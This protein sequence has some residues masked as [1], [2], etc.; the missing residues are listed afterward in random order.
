MR[1]AI[2]MT[3]KCQVWNQM[4]LRNEARKTASISSQ[5]A[6]IGVGM[7][8]LAV[9]AGEWVLRTRSRLEARA[10]KDGR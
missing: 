6:F 5:I 10:K 7:E 4:N 8:L 1:E 2:A 3:V 9:Y